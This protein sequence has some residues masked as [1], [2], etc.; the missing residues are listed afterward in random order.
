MWPLS[1]GSDLDNMLILSFVEQTRVLSLIGEE[2]ITRILHKRGI[3]F[4]TI[5]S[6]ANEKYRAHI[7]QKSIRHI[8]LYSKIDN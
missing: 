8:I 7:G 4:C 5:L 3:F 2:V 1:V 6:L